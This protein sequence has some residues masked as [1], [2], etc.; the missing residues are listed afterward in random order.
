MGG[1]GGVRHFLGPVFSKFSSAPGRIFQLFV[2]SR[3]HFYVSDNS[4]PQV[5]HLFALQPLKGGF[6]SAIS[7]KNE[8]SCPLKVATLTAVS[9]QVKAFVSLYL[10]SDPPPPPG[11]HVMNFL[12][13]CNHSSTCT[14]KMK[15]HFVQP[16]PQNCGP[17]ISL[18]VV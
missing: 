4:R 13:S 2:R 18:Q 11:L 15:Y 8:M 16:I 17:N 6:L 5:F 10:R 9:L 12:V 14:C 7:C 3:S 1:G